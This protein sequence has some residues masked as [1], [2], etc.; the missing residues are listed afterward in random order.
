MI[1][2]VESHDGKRWKP[3]EGYLFVSRERARRNL[4]WALKS[5]PG[6]KFRIKA[7]VRR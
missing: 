4:Q 6:M 1:W 5:F 7:Y 3:A 2:A